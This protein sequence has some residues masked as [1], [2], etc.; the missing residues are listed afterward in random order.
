MILF[1]SPHLDDVALSCGGLVARLAR[2]GEAVTVATL[3]TADAPVGC[4]LST[5]AQRL[6]A[7]WALG[8][9]PY[10]HRRAEDQRA[11]AVLG[12][13]A[14]HLN[15]DDAIYRYDHAGQPLYVENFI[16]GNVHPFDWEAHLPR[17]REA[18]KPLIRQA[19]TV[20]CPLALG[21]H[22]DHV[23][24]RQAVEQLVDF[25]QPLIYYE[26]FP[27]AY[28]SESAEA[29][30]L[31]AGMLPGTVALSEEEVALRIHAIACYASQMK[32][33]FGDVEAMARSVREY[34]A[35][36]GGERYWQR[37]DTF[38]AEE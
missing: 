15:L 23:I 3:H 26:D 14:V 29:S 11:C 27:Y 21:R 7:Q 16:G 35:R 2:N 38:R 4:P 33:L 10:V 36:V 12:A 24:T 32:E 1:I 22:V 28:L 34:V 8:D 30:E 20:Y 31:T 19:R 9:Q 25:A 6:H 37:L 13:Q 5:S 17:A 18:L